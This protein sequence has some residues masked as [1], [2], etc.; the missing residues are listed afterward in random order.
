VRASCQPAQVP[1]GQRSASCDFSLALSTAPP[2]NGDGGDGSRVVGRFC[3]QGGAGHRKGVGLVQWMGR[4]RKEGLGKRGV[5]LK[6]GVAARDVGS[7]DQL[8][9]LTGL[10]CVEQCDEVVYLLGGR[11]TCVESVFIST[12]G[13][14]GGGIV[15]DGCRESSRNSAI[16]GGYGGVSWLGFSTC[17]FNKLGVDGASTIAEALTALTALQ[18]LDVRLLY[19]KGVEC[20]WIQITGNPPD[21]PFD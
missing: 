5:R 10:D 15:R 1:F 21:D 12:V 7:S 16:G 13:W 8:G 17:S 4:L 6:H 2:Q 18:L 3:G 11:S 20:S 9:R 19:L 14:G